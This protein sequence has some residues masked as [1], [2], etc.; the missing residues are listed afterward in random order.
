MVLLV[1]ASA[2]A[3]AAPPK[4]A[5]KNE[6]VD[7]SVYGPWKDGSR[8][9]RAW[10][11]VVGERVV[12]E[13]L[14]WGVREKGL[15]QRVILDYGHVYVD[16]AELLRGKLVRVVGKLERRR[17]RAAPP[18]AQGYGEDF[19]YFCIKAEK[20]EQVDEVRAPILAEPIDGK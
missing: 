17:V 2:A 19:D 1:V 5:I 18:G 3:G 12:A 8:R 16:G 7:L 13:G 6:Q 9:V 10:P 11:D 15:G 20:I 4:V 14:A